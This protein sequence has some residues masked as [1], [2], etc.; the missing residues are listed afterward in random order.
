MRIR[1]TVVGAMERFFSSKNTSSSSSSSSA[2]WPGGIA[3]ASLSSNAAQPA[4]PGSAEQL[5]AWASADSGGAGSYPG[6]AG[7]LAAWASAD[8][9]G[10]GSYPGRNEWRFSSKSY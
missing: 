1:V 10:A 8:S 5:A 2:A 7:Q 3:G 4:D 6:S 9:G